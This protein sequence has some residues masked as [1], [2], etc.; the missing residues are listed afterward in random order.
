MTI[1]KISNTSTCNSRN[2]TNLENHQNDDWKIEN[3]RIIDKSKLR[4]E[5]YEHE[6]SENKKMK[7]GTYE[8]SDILKNI[9]NDEMTIDIYNN[10]ES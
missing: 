5:H 9:R 6:H 3:E 4:F 8:K 7:I 1:M 10:E 2:W